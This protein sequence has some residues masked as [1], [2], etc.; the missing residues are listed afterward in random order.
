MKTI[1]SFLLLFVFSSVGFTATDALKNQEDDIRET[2]FRWQFEHNASG[3][4]QKAKAY[5]LQIG[6]KDDPSDVFIKRFDEHKPPV[7]KA[8]ACT[9]DAINGVRDKKTGEKGL[10][11][12]ATS[13]EWKSATEVKMKGGYY[14][15]G[16]SA[17]GNIPK[18]F[19]I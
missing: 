14:E 13:I 12:R 11:F 17:T 8:S 10:L 9:A 16:L 2:V 1:A 7:R 19:E 3:Q 6:E 15:G 5:Y 4:Q 18:A